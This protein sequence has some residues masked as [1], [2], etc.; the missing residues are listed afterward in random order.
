MLLYRDCVRM[1]LL[2]DCW[3]RTGGTETTWNQIQCAVSC[4]ECTTQGCAFHFY[5]EGKV[6][7]EEGYSWYLWSS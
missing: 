7:S 3:D 4:S 5:N 6:K 2:W 1:L